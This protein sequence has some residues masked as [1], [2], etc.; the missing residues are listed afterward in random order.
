MFHANIELKEHEKWWEHRC[1]DKTTLDRFAKWVG[2]TNE[3]SRVM[4]RQH[5]FDKHY[6]SVLDIPCGLCIDYPILKYHSIDYLG[7]DITSSFVNRAISQNIPARLG[8]IQD[9]PCSDSS[10]DIVYSRHILEHLESYET[11]LK[12]LIRVA[13]KEIVIVFFRVPHNA[14]V[15][16]I[17]IGD[18]VDGYPIY[19]NIYSKP[20]LETFLSSVPKVKSLVWKS[21]SHTAECILYIGLHE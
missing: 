13:K 18:Y 20:K 14:D 11:A 10:F 9:I 4:V 5:I 16:S 8:R 6:Q 15:D 21:L 12:E 2:D 7:V 19:H 1:N 17:I 3:P